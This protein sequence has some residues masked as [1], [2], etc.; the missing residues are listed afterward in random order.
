MHKDFTISSLTS[1]LFLT[2]VI[3]TTSTAI[4]QEDS[5]GN[6]IPELGEECDDGNIIS[7]DGCSSSC[8]VEA[9]RTYAQFGC[10][11][12]AQDNPADGQSSNR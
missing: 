12:D 4:A 9:D 7:G 5:C 11:F 3:V 1:I 8:T 6:S 10:W 2:A